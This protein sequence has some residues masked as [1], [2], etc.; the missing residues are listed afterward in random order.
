[1]L[2]ITILIPTTIITIFNIFLIPEKYC[3]KYNQKDGLGT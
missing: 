2:S 3:K 1:M